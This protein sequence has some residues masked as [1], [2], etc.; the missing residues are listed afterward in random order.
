M[1][2]VAEQAVVCPVGGGSAH[3]DHGDVVNQEHDDREDGQTQ[4]AVGDDLIDLVGGGQLAGGVLLVAGL[5]DL[6]DVDIPL[7]GDDAL[8]VVVQLLLGGLDVGLDVRRG[9]LAQTQLFHDLVVTL[10]DLDGVPTLLLLGLIVQRGLLD[11][12]NGVLHGAGEGVHR[13]GLA[14]LGGIDGSLGSGHDTVA[15]QGGNLNDL[16]A[17]S[18]GQRINVNL[19][20]VLA[21]NVHHVDGDDHGNAQLG[22]LGGQVQ[23]PLQVGAVDDVQDGVGPLINQVIPGDHFLHGVRRQGINAGQVGDG[24]V[25]MLLQLA[26]LLLHRN[27]GP[28]AHE[29]VGTGEGIEQCGFAAVRV[30]RKGNSDIHDTLLLSA[31]ANV[32]SNRGLR[33]YD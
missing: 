8:G 11:V 29:L 10:E 19:V 7:V 26:F 21:D 28:V 33:P 25:G 30:A 6:A 22:Q 20:A 12:G 9:L 23:V 1:P 14:V 3:A 32:L 5:D 17:Q 4:P 2:A 31:L 27:A 15:L 24:N 16:A 18:L 13:H